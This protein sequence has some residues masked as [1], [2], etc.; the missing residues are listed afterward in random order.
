M[1]RSYQVNVSAP[2]STPVC[3]LAPSCSR[4]GLQ[5]LSRHGILRGGL[6]IVRRLRVCRAAAPGG[7][8]PARRA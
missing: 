6:L 1:V 8:V 5:V 7:A 3:N 2:R 4:Y